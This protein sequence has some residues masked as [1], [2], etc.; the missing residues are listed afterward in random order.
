M[1]MAIKE[2]KDLSAKGEKVTDE[3]VTKAYKAIDKAAKRGVIKG[4]NADRK[5][6]QVAKLAVKV[7]EKV[8]K[9][10]KAVKAEKK[11]SK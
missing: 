10:K 11:E 6:S 5:K 9:K 8:E 4:N 2:I 1:K 3:M 7:V